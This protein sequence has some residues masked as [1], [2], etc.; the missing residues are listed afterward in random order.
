[1]E[2]YGNDI[3]VFLIGNKIDA[4][5][6]TT[7]DYYSPYSVTTAHGNIMC[8]QIKGSTF[9]ECSSKSNEGIEELLTAVIKSALKFKHKFDQ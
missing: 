8:D 2:K 3:P 9:Y 7:S 1:M 5:A 4:L 6:K